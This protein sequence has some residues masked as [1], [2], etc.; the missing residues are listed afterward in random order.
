MRPRTA[1]LL[2]G[3]ASLRACVVAAPLCVHAQGS[4][5]AVG[6]RAQGSVVIA[7]W[8]H[9]AARGGAGRAPR[10]PPR[11]SE[12]SQRIAPRS[13]SS[14]A[15]SPPAARQVA[16]SGAIRSGRRAL[17]FFQS[18]LNWRAAG[19][20]AW[21]VGTG[22]H[23][24]RPRP[25]AAPLGVPNS[26]RREALLPTRSDRRGGCCAPSAPAA[27]AAAAAGGWGHS[28][29]GARLALPRG[30]EWRACRRTRGGATVRS[31]AG[32]SRSGS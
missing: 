16:R 25:P 8:E 4:V 20:R 12:P 30:G 1:G 7:C 15:P 29:R 17:R 9:P 13:A 14:V 24:S 3:R 2:A 11:A 22:T 6:R 32:P 23:R 31:S 27:P 28:A 10:A 26:R 18:A 21:E 19:A 5:T